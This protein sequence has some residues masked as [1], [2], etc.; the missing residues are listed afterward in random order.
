MIAARPMN[1]HEV[2]PMS[3]GY[4]FHLHAVYGEGGTFGWILR[5]RP[6]GIPLRPVAGEER[7]APACREGEEE[8]TARQSRSCHRAWIGRFH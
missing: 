3:A 4:S 8:T 2:R 1:K 7:E 5:L 6:T